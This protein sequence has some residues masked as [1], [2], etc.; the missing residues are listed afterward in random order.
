[1][2]GF[3]TAAI[4]I[5]LGVASAASSAY[6][7]IKQGN[8]SKK[9]ADYNAGIADAQATDALA[10]GREDEDRFRTDARR[11][12]GT[13]RA[14]IAASGVEVDS[15]S[16][17]DIQADAASLGE[18]DA[19][20]IRHNA[21]REAWGFGV[22]AENSRRQGRNAQSAG[23]NQAIGTTI[24]TGYSLLEAKYGWGKT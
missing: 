1:M 14:A 10:R 20:T 11:I 5:G 4:M 16:A 7:S 2:A 12:K 19:L 15:G 6:G 8:E 17:R 22:D 3:T 9:L 18:L 13:Q 21:E 24:G 23:R